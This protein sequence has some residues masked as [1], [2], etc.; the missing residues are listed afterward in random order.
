MSKDKITQEFD[1]KINFWKDSLKVCMKKL[2]IAPSS[3]ED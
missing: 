1:L 2:L 3:N